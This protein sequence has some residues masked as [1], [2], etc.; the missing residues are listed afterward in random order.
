MNRQLPLRQRV[1]LDY[2]L[3]GLVLSLATR[4]RRATP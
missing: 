1:A 4:P 3:I 2:G